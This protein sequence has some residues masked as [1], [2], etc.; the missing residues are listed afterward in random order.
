MSQ[1]LQTNQKR[2]LLRKLRTSRFFRHS[3]PGLRLNRSATLSRQSLRRVSRFHRKRPRRRHSTCIL[4][5]R[6]RL[7]RPSRVRLPA[8]QKPIWYGPEPTR[9]VPTL[10]HTMPIIRHTKT[11]HRWTRPRQVHEQQE[12]NESAAKRQSQRFGQAPDA[13][14]HS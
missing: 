7:R 8:P 11:C 3:P 2:K 10:D 12:I 9:L 1:R 14:P 6:R 13:S 5:M 4:R